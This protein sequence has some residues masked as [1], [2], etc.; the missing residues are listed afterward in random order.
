MS[1]SQQL[2]DSKY[3][4]YTTFTFLVS[5][6]R[7]ADKIYEDD[8]VVHLALLPHPCHVSARIFCS[9]RHPA[10]TDLPV[11]PPPP[12][13]AHLWGGGG[14]PITRSCFW[15]ARG[16]GGDRCNTTTYGM[17]KDAKDPCICHVDTSHAERPRTESSLLFVTFFIMSKS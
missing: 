10:C 17:A 8:A 15:L 11:L 14:G 5:L 6:F 3:A 2:I 4:L 13:P 12:P 1:K 9:L 16:E 7:S